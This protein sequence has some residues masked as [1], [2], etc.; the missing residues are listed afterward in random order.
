[1]L[2]SVLLLLLDLMLIVLELHQTAGV[3]DRGIQTVL[4]V[5]SAGMKINHSEIFLR[6]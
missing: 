2:E 1:M 4:I 6:L 3:Q 5:G